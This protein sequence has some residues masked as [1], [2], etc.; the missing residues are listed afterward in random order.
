ML[1]DKLKRHLNMHQSYTVTIRIRTPKYRIDLN[2]RLRSWYGFRMVWVILVSV[3][4]N[5]SK[6]GQKRLVFA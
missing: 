6:T 4:P 5:H 1:V 2:N 3:D